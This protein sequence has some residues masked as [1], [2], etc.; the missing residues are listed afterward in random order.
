L[1]LQQQPFSS[2]GGA[3]FRLGPFAG[4]ASSKHGRAMCRGS[5]GVA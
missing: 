5:S 1:K 3:N 2:F 4:N